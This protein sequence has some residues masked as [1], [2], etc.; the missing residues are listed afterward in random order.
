MLMLLVLGHPLRTTALW[1]VHA[2]WV[3][4]TADIEM[5]PGAYEA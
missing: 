1:S 5:E 2:V 4:L 3:P